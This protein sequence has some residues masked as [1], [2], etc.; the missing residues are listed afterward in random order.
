LTVSSWLLSLKANAAPDSNKVAAQ[1]NY[2]QALT[3]SVELGHPAIDHKSGT[4]DVSGT[5][6]AREPERAAWGNQIEFILTL[7]GYA[8][9]LGNIWRFPYLCY[10]NGGGEFARQCK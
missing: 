1:S 8:V 3:S 2:E 10:R 9:G 6:S 7:V 5:V 4:T